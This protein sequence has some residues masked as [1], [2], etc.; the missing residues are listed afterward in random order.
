MNS[1]GDEQITE[2]HQRLVELTEPCPAKYHH[3][4]D[5]TGIFDCLTENNQPLLDCGGTRKVAL[6][7]G[8]RQVCS[9]CEWCGKHHV[10]VHPS[11]VDAGGCACVGKGW[12]LSDS[13][14]DTLW[15]AFDSKP[16]VNT[17]WDEHGKQWG[18]VASVNCK[19]GIGRSPSRELSQWLAA[20][21]LVKEMEVKY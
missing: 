20:E 16:S 9:G 12:V 15:R 5:H 13:S 4:E 1:K 19:I 21:E 14:T 10:T 17:V 3:V 7:P 11:P 8:L 2:V 18:T 6:L